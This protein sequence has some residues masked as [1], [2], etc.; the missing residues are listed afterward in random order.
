MTLD[1]LRVLYLHGFASGPSSRKAR[2]LADRL[3]SAGTQLEAPDLTEGDFTRLT[4]TRQLHLLDRLLAG[5]PAVLIGS[6][7]GGYLA[8]LYASRH[9]E[10][11][12]LILLAPA[13]DF[14]RLWT[15]DLGPERI[16]QWRANGTTLVFNHAHG[17]EMPLDFGFLEDAR[18]YPP[19]PSFPQP[20]LIFHGNRDPV[21]PVEHSIAFQK[22]H[23]ATRLIRLDS[24]HELTDVL[25]PI[26][27]EVQPFLLAG[28]S[29]VKC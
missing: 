15:L 16:D 17:R 1:S 10:V 5:Q 21:V 11:A 29:P 22:A 20:A 26:W 4:V 25:E 9:A 7:L 3:R 19:F 14:Y 28:G 2:F 6:S 8:A 12:R 23:P 18:T 13:F 27:R 24:A